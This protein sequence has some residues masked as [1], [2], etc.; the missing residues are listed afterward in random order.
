MQYLLNIFIGEYN[1]NTQQVVLF[2][3]GFMISFFASLLLVLHGRQKILDSTIEK[4]IF[5]TR[6]L[7]SEERNAS[8]LESY[9]EIAKLSH[10]YKNHFQ[11]I[12][13][14]LKNKDVDDISDY[15]ERVVGES[16]KAITDCTGIP[17]IDAV[18]SSKSDIARNN[19][20]E[21]FYRV[22]PPIFAEINKTDICTV[23]LNLLDNAIEA[24]TM[25]N[26]GEKRFIRVAASNAN[27][28]Y[29]IKV[30]NSYNVLH[31][32]KDDNESIQKNKNSR[33]GYG[34]KIVEGIADRY[35]GCLTVSKQ[36]NTF[37]A[38]VLLNS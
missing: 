23:L 7:L 9:R 35:S 16:P 18:L 31:S 32:A 28:M 17:A 29:F 30:E 13:M 21:F 1:R 19:D 4:E 2:A 6:L 8:T 10:D 33:R 14:L 11:V 36:N 22:D 5:E 25:M 12:S 20:I 37:S 24:C 15:I 34:L 26:D 27:A 3:F 38:I